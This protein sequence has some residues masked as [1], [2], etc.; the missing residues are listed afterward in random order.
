MIQTASVDGR[1]MN[2]NTGKI[3]NY[4]IEL[5]TSYLISKELL[6][7]ANYS[8]LNMERAIL[9]SPEHKFYAGV[10]FTKG[11]LSA[12]TG[13]QYIAGLYTSLESKT[14]ENYLLWNVRGSFRIAKG[15]D[16][17][18]KGE[19]LLNQQYEINLGFPM[20]GATVMGGVNINF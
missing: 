1:P 18:V 10:D 9:A 7:M 12:S 17:Y 13:M 3:E 20:P 6:I 8:F 4:G 19:N 15:I 5:S 2:I 16:L 14:K 11:R